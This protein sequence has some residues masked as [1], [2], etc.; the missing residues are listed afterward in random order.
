MKRLREKFTRW[1][2]KKG[3]TFNGG[4]TEIIFCC[5]WWVKPFVFLFSPSVYYA[6]WSEQF[7]KWFLESIKKGGTSNVN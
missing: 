1:Y 7:M 5:P 3:Y 6:A 2:V 4:F